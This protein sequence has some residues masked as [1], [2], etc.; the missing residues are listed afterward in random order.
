VR[1]SL[2]I[3]GASAAEERHDRIEAAQA[4]ALAE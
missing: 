3:D 4:A 1:R 2:T